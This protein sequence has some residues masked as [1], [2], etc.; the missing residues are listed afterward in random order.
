[1]GK[2]RSR[3]GK[4]DTPEAREAA[5]APEPKRRHKKKEP[6]PLSEPLGQIAKEH[7]L[8]TADHLP[9]QLPPP[10]DD[11]LPKGP[12]FESGRHLAAEPSFAERVRPD[13]PRPRAVGEPGSVFTSVSGGFRLTEDGQERAF[14]FRDE[15]PPSEDEK[16]ALRDIGMDYRPGRKVWAAPATPEVRERSDELA[17]RMS[18]KRDRIDDGRAR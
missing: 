2:T 6:T 12:P 15:L 13:G 8:T 11:D 5:H 17:L 16:A 9:R 3:T 18:G 1:M 7:G 10:T 14:R 4:D